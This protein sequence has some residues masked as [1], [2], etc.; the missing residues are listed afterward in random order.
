MLPPG[1]GTHSHPFVRRSVPFLI[2]SAPP[3][4]RRQAPAR[5]YAAAGRGP[6]ARAGRPAAWPKHWRQATATDE[7][8]PAAPKTPPRRRR[9][10]T[11]RRGRRPR[12]PRA[13]ARASQEVRG[14]DGGARRRSPRTSHGQARTARR[15]DSGTSCAWSSCRGIT[16][17]E[18]TKELGVDTSGLYR[19]GHSRDRL[20]LPRLCQ[21]ATVH[22][23]LSV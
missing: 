11:P 13:R 10:S 4:R 19:P 23:S 3:K 17:S 18:L 16:V 9:A 15:A 14:R 20:T 5:A 8:R 7:Q 12:A 6:R 2:S 1:G 22:P 21:G